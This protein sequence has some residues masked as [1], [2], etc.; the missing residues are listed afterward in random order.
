MRSILV[1][2]LVLL[3]ASCVTLSE[4]GE[5]KGSQSVSGPLPYKSRPTNARPSTPAYAPE[6]PA[7][8]PEL[9][10][11]NPPYDNVH[12]SWK[13]RLD[14]PY[15][16]LKHSG[17]YT[18]TG[19]LIPL[20]HK[21][22]FD[23]GLEAS[24]PPFALYF[25]DPGRVPLEGLRSRACVPVAGMRSPKAPLMYD[26]LPSTTVVYAVVSGP[27]PEVPRAYPGMYEYMKK[28]NWV[29][30]GPIREIYLIS[31]SSVENWDELMTEVQL[32]ATSG[33]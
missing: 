9:P 19:S 16:Y 32:P 15:V 10:V 11:T 22:L 18:D 17:S 13:Q 8:V 27:Y 25:D 21:E 2:S 23:Q 24:G 20:L 3:V 31:P 28:M 26:V 4:S 12:A 7:Y 1:S 6:L 29:E 14:Q 5:I 33:R 30:D